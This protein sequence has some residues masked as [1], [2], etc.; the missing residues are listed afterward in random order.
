MKDQLPSAFLERLKEILPARNFSLSCQTFSAP[1]QICLRINTLKKNVSEV[2]EFFKKEDISF[3]ED[4]HD[5]TTI[6]LKDTT[7][8]KENSSLREAPLSLFLKS[9]P[10]LSTL[11]QE[12][13][14]YPQSLSSLLPVRVL[15]PQPGELVLD[16]CAAPGSKTTQMAA[17][18]SNQ[19]KIVALEVVKERFYK[20]KS[21]VQ[22]LGAEIVET[23]LVDA[24]RFRPIG[25]KADSKPLFD[26]ALVDVPCSSEGRFKLFESKS[27]AYWSVRKIKEMAHKQ[28]GLLLHAS[29]FVKP[30]GAIL[31]ST[32]TFAPEENEMVVDWFLRKSGGDFQLCPIDFN[33][34]T[35]Y[36]A[37][38][39]WQ[40]KIFA[41]DMSSCCRILP[42]LTPRGFLFEGFFLAHLK[43]KEL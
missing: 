24:R 4:D 14:V 36:P 34:V 27:Y 1:Q 15:D 5:P 3:M 8:Q 41:S 31:Y 17:R 39:S 7:Q 30:S 6:V 42:G 10:K 18:M 2:L 20:L 28:K 32:C 29:R 12:G 19:G 33:D 38:T 21:V 13:I 9:H 40:G 23:R 43:R 37:M 16:M 11:I 25:L 35:T 22:L 26:K